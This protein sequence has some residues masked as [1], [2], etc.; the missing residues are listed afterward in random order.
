MRRKG[1][2]PDYILAKGIH[3]AIVDEDTWERAKALR[4]MRATGTPRQYSGNFPLTSL[5]KCPDCGSYMTSVYGAKRKNGTKARY[6]ACGQYH[7]KGRTVCNPN[8]INAD[9]LEKAVFE[10]LENVLSSDVMIDQITER[11]NAQ[12]KQHPNSTK[13]TKEMEA[14]KKCLSELEIRKKRIQEAFE[15]GSDLFTPT[16]A[17][18]RMD[19]IQTETSEIQNE[20]FKLQQNETNNQTAMKPVSPEFVKN[21]L[22]EFLELADHLEPLEFRDLLIASIERIKAT[23]KE[24]KN[25]HFSFIAHLTENAKNPL[26]DSALHTA[27]KSQ[28]LLL[29][30]LYFTSNHYLFV[31]R[32]TPHNPKPS[33]YLLQQH[34]FHQ[35]VRK[36]HFRKRQ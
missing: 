31:I 14:F 20:L 5:A 1:K 2:N 24:L 23:K 16:E 7:N 12:M 32:F 6:Y 26:S 11:I 18:E 36:C 25:I 27:S 34:Q 3:E 4:K 13:K 19:K 33:I 29:R 9:W 35:L 21:Q 10:R 15:M 17:K 28:S 8:L 22:G 30:G